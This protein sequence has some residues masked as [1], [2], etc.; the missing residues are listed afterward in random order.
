MLIS[1]TSDEYLENIL[2][3]LERLFETSISISY[4]NAGYVDPLVKAS[5][6][7]DYQCN[8]A[9][10][11][12]KRLKIS[13]L[14]IARTLIENTPPNNL[15]SSLQL[16]PPGFIN[17][18]I[19][20]HYISIKTRAIV[21]NDIVMKDEKK[22]KVIID[23]SSPN[24]AKEMHVGHLR[25]TIIGDCLANILEFIGHEVIRVNHVGDWG[26]QFG[27]LLAHLFEK[28]PNYQTSMPSIE[29]LQSFYKESKERFDAEE[30]F[31]KRA[32][33]CVVDLQSKQENHILAWKLICDISRKEFNEIYRQLDIYNLIERG[34][35]FY[36]DKMKETVADL[37]DRNLTCCED[38]R[39]LMFDSEHT[40]PLT[41]VKSDGGYTYDTS[42]MACLRYRVNEEKANRIIYVTD[43]G[44]ESRFTSL[45]ACAKTAGYYDPAQVNVEHVGF[46]LVL[47]NC[48]FWT[49]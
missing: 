41:L 19:N 44:Q 7:S 33:Q 8:V 29:D 13:P 18:T 39:I 14:D 3:A 6:F 36:Q 26:T 21:L 35:S 2:A 24:I 5:T 49:K 43:A 23:Y 10:P 9:M 17:I 4:P 28:F 25:S 22:D 16:A 37:K 48:L 31:K 47:G 34:E 27:M 11:L 12:S 15:I 46:G 38:G 1:A 45:F 32:Y 42:D 30:E 20:P 40:L